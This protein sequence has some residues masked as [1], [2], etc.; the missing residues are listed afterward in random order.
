MKK[1]ILILLA[2]STLVFISCGVLDNDDD[3]DP[4]PPVTNSIVGTWGYTNPDG[5]IV[6]YT[7]NADNTFVTDS[8]EQSYTGTYE[9]TETVNAGQKHELSYMV[10]TDNGEP[11]CMGQTTDNAGNSGIYL[12]QFYNAT[13]I[14][15]ID[16]D[17]NPIDFIKIV[18]DHESW[19]A[20]GVT[21]IELCYPESFGDF[22][23]NDLADGRGT[24][25]FMQMDGDKYNCS[26][27]GCDEAEDRAKAACT[28]F[29]V[30][31]DA[32]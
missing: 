26:A 23:W 25:C 24:Q 8:D 18:C 7:F 32:P 22:E 1:V 28:D 19:C 29:T 30:S 6:T 17:G 2:L 20:D 10:E 21:E 5:C 15:V 4:P 13:E 9:F 11:N 27:N 16:E 14:D 12:V 3:D 31:W